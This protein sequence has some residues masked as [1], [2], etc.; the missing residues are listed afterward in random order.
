MI[1][2]RKLTHDDYDDIVEISKDLW[3]GADYLPELFHQ[4]VDDGEGLFIGAVD[5]DNGKVIGTDKYSVLSDGTGWLEGLRMHKDYRGRGISKEMARLTLNHAKE[6][7]RLGKIRTI[8]FSTHISAV[9]SIGLMTKLGFKLSQQYILVQKEFE[10]MDSRLSRQDFDIK[11]WDI[12]FEEFKALPYITK[13]NG[14]L[15]F[16]FY[17]QEPTPA[18]FEE[19]KQEGCFVCING[20]NGLYK[21]KGD[22]HFICIDETFRGINDFMNYYLLSLKGKCPVPPLVSVRA[23]DQDLLELLKASGYSTLSSLSNWEC[24]YLYF[25][26]P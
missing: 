15:P 3:D 23:E 16:A 11:A 7:R 2:Y 19:L 4:W 18:L 8:A 5:S 24:D 26:Y 1:E 20:H 12:D 25:T 14:I 21:L 17:F 22:P 6:Q 9:E 10:K 13:R